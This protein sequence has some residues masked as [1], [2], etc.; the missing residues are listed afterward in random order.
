MLGSLLVLVGSLSSWRAGSP[1]C[2]GAKCWPSAVHWAC[3]R[4]QPS[5][6]STTRLSALLTGAFGGIL[7]SAQSFLG[8]IFAHFLYGKCR[9][10]DPRQNRWAVC[11]ALPGSASAPSATTTAARRGIFCMLLATVIFTLA[12]PWNKSVTKKA[13]S[14]AV[15]FL[16]LFV[17]GAGSA[18]A[19]SGCWAGEPPPSF[20]RALVPAGACSI[21]PSSAAPG[22]VIWAL[23]MK[24]NPVSRATAI[25]GFVNPVVNVLL[26]ALL[27]GEPLFRW[28][29]LGALVLRLRRHLARG[30]SPCPRGGALMPAPS[31]TPT[32]TTAPAPCSTPTAY[33]LLDSLP[34][35]GRGGRLRA[36]HP[37]RR[38]APGCWSWPTRY[39]WV[40]GGHPHPPGKPARPGGLRRGGPGPDRRRLRRRLGGG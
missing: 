39:P 22:Y 36:G 5:M 11:W 19:R 4:P 10:D 29:Y 3:G 15:C 25:F 14:F 26:S 35:Q 2:P 23:L 8:V 40:C 33:A 1:R 32:P 6:R 20:R 17:G 27:N 18:A 34:D 37:L 30:R 21:W 12:G 7:N 9:P 28:Q 38:R 24:N 31:L 13:D 16:N